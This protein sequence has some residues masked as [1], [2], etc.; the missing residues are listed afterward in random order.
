MK[1]HS[2]LATDRSMN[3]LHLLMIG[4]LL[5]GIGRFAD[6]QQ[7]IPSDYMRAKQT[8]LEIV[9]KSDSFRAIE[10][11]STLGEPE[12]V[13]GVFELVTRDL[14]W[15]K[16]D[17][18]ATMALGR[19]AVQYGL[20]ASL[21]MA[22]RDQKAAYRV[23]SQAKSIAY[24]LA[25]FSWPGWD[26]KGIGISPSDLILGQDAAKTNLR[27]A[28]SL[29]KGDLPMSRA[30][31]VLGAHHLAAEKLPGARKAFVEGIKYAT[32]AE[33]KGLELLLR[34]YVYLVD[35]LEQPDNRQLQ[36]EFDFIKTELARSQDGR[37]YS[38]QLKT[39]YR[40][41]IRQPKE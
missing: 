19:A 36:V 9:V 6:A 17:L 41:F 5:L 24:D 40:V 4:F 14:Y 12:K 34:G 23:R 32:A 2:S 39:A 11:I 29:R 10:Y 15:E 35:M 22:A 1:H 33:D 26:E 16:K 3:L 38:D 18:T 21:Q 27:L 25:S 7:S 30:F 28:V 8:A 37:S 13:M 20:T 31:W